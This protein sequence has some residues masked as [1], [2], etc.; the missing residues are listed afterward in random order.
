LRHATL[1]A[2]LLETFSYMNIDCVG[3]LKLPPVDMLHH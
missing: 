2:D 3:H 1:I